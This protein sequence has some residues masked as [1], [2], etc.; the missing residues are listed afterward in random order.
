MV[1]MAVHG[2]YGCA[3]SRAALRASPPEG[4]QHILPLREIRPVHSSHLPR[5][6]VPLDETERTTR[7]QLRIYRQPSC[8]LLVVRSLNSERTVY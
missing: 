4:G 8:C 1:C 7:F 2:L 3:T 5:L 6:A